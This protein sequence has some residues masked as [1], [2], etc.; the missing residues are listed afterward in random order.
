MQKILQSNTENQTG[1]H[2]DEFGSKR[3][4]NW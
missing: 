4:E 1:Y 3:V 2:P